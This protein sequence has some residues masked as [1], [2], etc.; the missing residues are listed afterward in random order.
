LQVQAAQVTVA[1]RAEAETRD[2]LLDK[3]LSILQVRGSA[4]LVK[5]MW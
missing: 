4:H 2:Q 3:L 5:Q 1:S